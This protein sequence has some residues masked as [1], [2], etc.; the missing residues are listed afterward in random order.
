MA[1][2]E[3]GTVLRL[4]VEDTNPPKV[5]YLVIVGTCSAEV[6]TVFINSETRPTNLPTGLRSLQLPITTSDLSC[7]T[8]ESYVDCADIVARDKS[9]LNETLTKEPTRKVGTLEKDKI[10]EIVR[11][12]KGADT[13][14]TADKKKFNLL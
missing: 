12:V 10:D 6:A 14:S 9:K 8:Y 5:K 4:F 3:I 13:I 2:F 1:L 11:L 7:L